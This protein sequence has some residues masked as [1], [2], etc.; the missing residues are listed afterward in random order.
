MG[1][2]TPTEKFLKQTNKLLERITKRISECKSVKVQQL[3]LANKN[4]VK[5]QFE[6]IFIK[7]V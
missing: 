7:I 1:A 2:S 4:R 3:A 6:G 5:G